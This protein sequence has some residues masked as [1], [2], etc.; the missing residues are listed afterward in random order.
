MNVLVLL[1]DTIHK[2]EVIYEVIGSKG[3]SEVVVRRQ[4]LASHFFKAIESCFPNAKQITVHNHYEFNTLKNDLQLLPDDTHVIHF[5]SNFLISDLSEA[6]LTLR[7]LE[8]I[9]QNYTLMS[10]RKAVGVISPSII[11]YEKFL[12]LVLHDPNN[13]SVNASKKINDHIPISGLTNI[14]EVENFIQCIAGNFDARYFNSLK[15]DEYTIIK[16]SSN[17]KKIKA[18]YTFYHLLPEDMQMWFVEP[19]RYSENNEKASYCME[20][21]HMTDLAIK[22][23]HGSITEEELSI[24]LDKYFYFFRHR[25]TREISQEEYRKAADKLYVDKVKDRIAELKSMPEFEKMSA[26]LKINDISDIDK[27]TER[28]FSLKERLEKHIKRLNI[29]V[30]GHGDP[31]F[32]NTMYHKSTRTLKFIDPKGALTENELWTDPYYDIAK[33][34]HSICG[35]YD[36]FNNDLFEIT[37]DKQFNTRLHIDFD[38]SPYVEL[39]RKKLEENHYDYRLV[40]LYEASLFLS[41]LPLHIDNPHK[42]YGFILNADSILKEIESNV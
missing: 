34:S 33:L 17:K 32:A 14:G 30:I 23:V 13:S 1:D 21:L 9:D 40:R 35:C 26:L 12:S 16:S 19:F 3:F 25:H 7:K 6:S 24:I 10:E 36:F 31:C 27:L 4:T 20:R 18:E 42:V 37:I 39:F 2:S 29:S 38:N 22:W 11:Y 28:Y 15:G 5:F 8:F 41:M